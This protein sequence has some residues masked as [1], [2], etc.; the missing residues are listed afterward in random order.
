VQAVPHYNIGLKIEAVSIFE[1]FVP[2]CQSTTR[3]IPEDWI[4]INTYVKTPILF[5]NITFKAIRMF[6]NAIY[7]SSAIL[8]FVFSHIF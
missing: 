7:R 8:N 3:H 1:T 4:F 6:N 2:L 5:W